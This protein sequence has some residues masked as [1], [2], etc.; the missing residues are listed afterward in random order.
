MSTPRKKHTPD[1]RAAIRAAA[2][3]QGIPI[4]VLARRVGVAQPSLHRAL[5][6]REAT[7]RVELAERCMAELGL[8][9]GRAK[10]VGPPGDQKPRAI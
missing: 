1:L 8:A 7:M 5:S 2:S 10:T 9:V 4:A 6:R 3:E